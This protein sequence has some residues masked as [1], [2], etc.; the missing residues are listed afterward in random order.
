MRGRIDKEASLET[1]DNEASV[2]DEEEEEDE[3]G[4]S[5]AW[6]LVKEARESEVEAASDPGIISVLLLL[7]V[8]GVARLKVSAV[9]EDDML[10]GWLGKQVELER[11]LRLLSDEEEE[12]EQR[13]PPPPTL[14][15][16]LQLAAEEES[17]KPEELG[18]Q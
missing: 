16:A 14:A 3:T 10:R 15:G 17:L 9:V 2:D 5:V 1:P 8:A 6:R 4:V 13:A 12:E 11:L 7:P 18:G